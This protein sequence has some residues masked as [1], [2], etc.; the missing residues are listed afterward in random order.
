[1]RNRKNLVSYT[2]LRVERWVW[3]YYKKDLVMI[4]LWRIYCPSREN[5]T[6]ERYPRT[7]ENINRFSQGVCSPTFL[8][9]VSSLC[10]EIGSW[11]YH[12]TDD[13]AVFAELR[14]VLVVCIYSTLLLVFFFFPKQVWFM[15]VTRWTPLFESVGFPLACFHGHGRDSISHAC[16]M[17]WRP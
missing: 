5:M 16:S 15:F 1:M 8:D 7:C 3:V 11:L 12:F 4:W 9:L 17:N 6:F 2:S 14:V 13:M 10:S